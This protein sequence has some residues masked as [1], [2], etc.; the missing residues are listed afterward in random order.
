MLPIFKTTLFDFTFLREF[1]TFE[2][3][4]FTSRKYSMILKF[5][6]IMKTNQTI[7]NEALEYCVLRP[8]QYEFEQNPIENLVDKKLIERISELFVE[9]PTMDESLKVEIINLADMIV[10]YCE[11]KIDATRREQI[12]KFFYSYMRQ[13]DS[14]SKFSSFI[15]SVNFIKAFKTPEKVILQVYLSLL[16]ASQPEGKEQVKKAM[17]ILLPVL[18]E[19]LPLV[20]DPKSTQTQYPVYIKITKKLITEEG[21]SVS[22][23]VHVLQTIARH[24]KLFY[25]YRELFVHHIVSSLSKIGLPS[26]PSADN[27]KLSIEL[28]ELLIEW[29]SFALENK[30]PTEE[31][32]SE[33]QT[34][35]V[36]PNSKKRRIVEDPE[37]KKKIKLGD[38][39]HISD[40]FGELM[41]NFLIKAAITPLDRRSE[42]SQIQIGNRALKCLKSALQ[43]WKNFTL[44]TPIDNIL[45][46]EKKSQENKTALPCI[47]LEILSLLM[48]FNDACGAIVEQKLLKYSAPI[49]N[50]LNSDDS[51]VQQAVSQFFKV[52]VSKP[53]SGIKNQF[54]NQIW[55]ILKDYFSKLE[56]LET[57]TSSHTYFVVL[58]IMK[59]KFPNYLPNYSGYLL[60]ILT[61]LVKV[62]IQK[63]HDKTHEKLKD[64]QPPR[65]V[66]YYSF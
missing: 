62:H 14:P 3:I 40:Q 27:K 10:R 52:C 6:D 43:I 59:D 55:E 51:V 16:K 24:S 33:I 31:K 1:Y 41:I 25:E 58:D 5:L 57:F 60:K 48:E 42:L 44:I 37:Q 15:L 29:E 19:R 50:L 56:N 39:F 23:L 49:A 35:I 18:P 47:G 22:K 11:T 12:L 46:S 53:G 45:I 64:K 65:S 36:S 63:T 8:L 28:V 4:K 2:V 17:D 61:K 38:T 13:E 30:E 9:T 7:K 66:F 21:L 54:F 34:E 20:I 26:A 32:E